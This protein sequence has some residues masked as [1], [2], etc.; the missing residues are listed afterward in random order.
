[1]KPS[2]TFSQFARYAVVGGV[3]GAVDTGSLVLLHIFCG[4]P[5][6]IAAAIAFILGLIT[7][8]LITIA[9]VFDTTGKFKEEFAL[10]TLI[11]IGGLLWTELILWGMVSLAHLSLPF[12]KAAALFLVLIWNFGMRKKFVF[13]G[14]PSWNDPQ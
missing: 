5:T 10:F 2:N 1:M 3:A 11:G 14:A 9:W 13:A 8:Y 7:N 12:S 6:L 4:V